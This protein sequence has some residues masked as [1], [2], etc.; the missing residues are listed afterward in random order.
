ML[1][2]WGW[3]SFL[4]ICFVSG[5]VFLS[6]T[7]DPRLSY[8]ADT[9][10]TPSCFIVAASPEAEAS[11]HVKRW[12]RLNY[13]PPRGSRRSVSSSFR[14]P[15]VFLGGAYTY[16]R[17]H[18]CRIYLG[19]VHRVCSLCTICVKNISLRCGSWAFDRRQPS[20]ARS[21]VSSPEEFF[22]FAVLLQNK[23]SSYKPG[24]SAG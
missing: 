18:R 5:S 6:T 11:S 4:K 16:P 9:T 12:M 20:N 10:R 24:E 17:K 22:F 21:L 2:K 7:I 19:F 1:L 3:T 8:D 23:W 14:V 13:V 15:V